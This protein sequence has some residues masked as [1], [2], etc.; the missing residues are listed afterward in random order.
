ML[1]HRTEYGGVIAIP[2]SDLAIAVEVRDDNSGPHTL[3]GIQKIYADLREQFPNAQ[4]K[5]ANLTDIAEAVE[6][7]RSKLPVLTQEIGDT[8]IYGIPSDPVK[9]ARYRE[10]LRLRTEWIDQGKFQIADATD[11]KFLSKFALAAEHTWGTDTKTWLDFDHYTPAA[12]DSMLNDP[13]YKTVTGSWVEKRADIDDS[14]A[15]LPVEL[16]REAESRLNALKPKQP[17]TANLKQKAD[18]TFETA[19]FTIGLDR[20]TGAIARLTDKARGRDWASAANPLALFSYRT[21]SKPDYDRF[22]A[23]YITVQTDWA[24]KDF[25]KPNIEKFGAESKVW[26]PKIVECWSGENHHAHTVLAKLAFPN[27]QD[28][29]AWPE[30]VYLELVFPKSAPEIHV[31]LSWFYKRANR[32]PEALWLTFKPLAPEAKGWL[33]YKIEPAGLRI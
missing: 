15:G 12:L 3:E 9:V 23:S 22:L 29:T 21:F 30:R 10:L 28:A 6:P 19:H 31:N 5:A 8:W 33:L 16:C 20:V 26:S 17:S 32:L 18:L 7:H 4:V 1:Y 2:S 14:V 25:G 13:K 27:Q 24:P 11:L